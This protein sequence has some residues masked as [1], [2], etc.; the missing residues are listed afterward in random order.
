[1]TKAPP[2]KVLVPPKASVPVPAVLNEKPAPPS[3]IGPLTVRTP[4]FKVTVRLLPSSTAPVPKFRLLVPPKV[5]SAFQFCGTLPSAT[6]AVVLS[7]TPPLI[8]SVP[9][10]RAL[11]LFT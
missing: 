9:L 8:V 4:P 2:E 6:P 7:M 10:P 3:E 1:M 5:K 11:L